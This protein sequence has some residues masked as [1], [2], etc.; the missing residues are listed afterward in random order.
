MLCH[1]VSCYPMSCYPMSCCVV[2]SYVMLCHMLCCV[3]LCL[4]L[5][6]LFILASCWVCFSCCRIDAL[7]CDDPTTYVSHLPIHQVR[8]TV[9]LPHRQTVG[10]VPHLLSSLSL[11]P[12][13]NASLVGCAGRNV[14]RTAALRGTPG[15]LVLFCLC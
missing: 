3:M 14:Q 15:V 9:T 10:V 1:V 5:L 6:L 11:V 12:V 13:D 7:A 8:V 4:T 2:L